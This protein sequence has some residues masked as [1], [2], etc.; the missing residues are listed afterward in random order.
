MGDVGFLIIT[1]LC[2]YKQLLDEA[3]HDIKNY[4]DRGQ[5]W[6]TLSEVWII[7]DVMHKLNPIIVLLYIQNSDRCKE[8]FAVKRLLQLTF[9]TASAHFCCFVNSSL[10]VVMSS[11]SNKFFF[12]QLHQIINDIQQK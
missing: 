6:I 11:V 5:H 3:E 10:E 1:L 7:H 2:N 8:I 9:Q 4:P 12:G